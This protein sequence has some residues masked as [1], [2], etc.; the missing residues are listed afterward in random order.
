[1]LSRQ[2]EYRDTM[3]SITYFR[4]SLARDQKQN[5]RAPKQDLC[6]YR[7]IQLVAGTESEG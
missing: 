3:P 6:V 7:C 1:M 5:I 2:S 4:H